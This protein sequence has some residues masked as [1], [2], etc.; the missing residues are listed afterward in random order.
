MYKLHQCDQV[1]WLTE[2]TDSRRGDFPKFRLCH[3]VLREN[4]LWKQ[5]GCEHIHVL[6]IRRYVT[7]Q[8]DDWIC[9]FLSVRG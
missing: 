4:G 1:S 8:G 5:G 9:C 3:T 2:I 7:F 6:L